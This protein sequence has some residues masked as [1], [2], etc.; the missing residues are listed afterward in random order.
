MARAASLTLASTHH[1]KNPSHAPNQTSFP[2]GGVVNCTIRN[3]GYGWQFGR[4]V[5]VPAKAS[6]MAPNSSVT[7]ILPSVI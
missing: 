2:V 6:G 4:G 7:V 3:L 1:R 5:R